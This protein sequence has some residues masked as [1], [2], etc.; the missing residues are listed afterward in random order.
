[1]VKKV[2]ASSYN[3]KTIAEVVETNFRE[4]EDRTALHEP[5]LQASMALQAVGSE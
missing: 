2:A 1:M 4:V 5:E 3:A